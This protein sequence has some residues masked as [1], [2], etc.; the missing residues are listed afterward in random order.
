MKIGI[1]T[2]PP[3][4][5]Y[6][7]ILQAYALQT[8]LERM[9]HEV[10][11]IHLKRDEIP[12]FSWRKKFLCYTKRFLYRYIFKKKTF[13]IFHEERERKALPIIRQH[14]DRFISQYINIYSINS[15]D[16]LGLNKTF[17]AYVV[18][19]DQVWRPL[20]S[21]WDIEDSFL[22]FD[23]RQDT[24]RI[25]YAASFGVDTWE[26]TPEQ[27]TNCR[28]LIRRFDFISVRE[29]SAVNLCRHHLGVDA[30]WVLDPTM[31]LKIEDYCRL[32]SNVNTEKSAGNLSVYILDNNDE[33]KD[34]V[35]KIANDLNLVPFMVNS[36]IENYYA[37]LEERIQP[38]VESWLRGFIDAEFIITDSYHGCVLSIM[39]HKPFVVFE[40]EGR[41]MARVRSL[42]ELLKL[43]DR[44][45]QL[46]YGIIVSKRPI[47][48]EGIDKI[49]EERKGS[50]ISML[51]A[52]LK[53]T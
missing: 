15:F 28:E 9:G 10:Y 18:G 19:S 50:S 29:K 17:D 26:F 22:R 36:V 33:K 1:L 6:G 45:V 30:E 31:L 44:I 48:W 14:T 35:N 5:N 52:S 43:Q 32:V 46:P 27:T 47:D 23:K 16:E 49:L 3:R 53:K 37:P 4:I 21:L 24:I 38:M 11:V 2:M 39:F 42:L 13:P 12:N 7:G 8:I 41:G 34:F 40:N 20:Y 51:T 25:A